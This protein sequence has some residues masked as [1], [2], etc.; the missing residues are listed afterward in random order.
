M[1]KKIFMGMAISATL[2]ASCSSEEPAG[3]NSG[4]NVTFTAT[5]P[6]DLQTRAYGDGT[7]ATELKYVVYNAD[8]EEISHFTNS[9]PMSNLK[10]TVNLNLVADQTYTIVFWAQ[11]PDAP[12]TLDSANG[13]IT[14]T[15]TGPAQSEN[16]D[17]F[18]A[19]ETFT[20]KICFPDR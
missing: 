6:G 11:A 9:V 1:I 13:T 2:L 15:P 4:G 19:S 10:A 3:G 18:F 14:V 7:T 5:L 17:A 8:G 16:R 12:Y 20:V